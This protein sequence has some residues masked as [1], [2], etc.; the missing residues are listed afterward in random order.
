[1][2]YTSN[3]ATVK[4]HPD[5]ISVSRG[6][7]WWFK[8]EIYLELAPPT[9]EM[10]KMN[11]HEKFV[12]LFRQHLATLDVHEWAKKCE[13]KILCCWENIK[14]KTCHRQILVEW[15]KENGYEA[16]EWEKPKPVTVAEAEAIFSGKSEATVEKPKDN[17][18][19]LELID[20]PKKTINYG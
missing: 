14:L 7:P 11:D 15:F 20:S 19:Q 18:V 4:N 13:G 17:A 2:I 5:A 16:M 1:M 10:V 9:W 8:K 3:Y 12:V 6:R